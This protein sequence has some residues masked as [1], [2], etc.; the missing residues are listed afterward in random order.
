MIT[1]SSRWKAWWG[2]PGWE[3]FVHVVAA[4][5]FFLA[6]GVFL[7]LADDAP[8]GDYLPIETKI[9]QSLRTQGQPWGP[10]GTAEVVT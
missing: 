7:E 2:R 3:R 9:M 10:A 4:V 8:E 6:I 1:T 5:T